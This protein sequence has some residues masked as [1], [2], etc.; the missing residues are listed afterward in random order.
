MQHPTIW[1][2]IEG[3]KGVQKSRDKI[4]AEFTRGDPSAQKRSKYLQADERIQT[5]V[6]EGFEMRTIV[7]FLQGIASQFSI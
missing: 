2:F 3:L 7:E 4:F 5:I 1:K 6:E